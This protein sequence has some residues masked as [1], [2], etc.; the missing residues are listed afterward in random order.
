MHQALSERLKYYV[1]IFKLTWASLLIIGGGV[2]G[3]LLK[4]RDSFTIRLALA[5]GVLMLVTVV[6]LFLVDN[7]IRRNLRRME[8]QKDV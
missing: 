7:R 4:E 6:I 1:E 3:L 5:G 2:T 8:E